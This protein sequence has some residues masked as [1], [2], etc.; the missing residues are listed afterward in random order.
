[1]EKAAICLTFGEQSENHAGMEINGDGLAETGFTVDELRDIKLTLEEKG[2]S[3]E[4]HILNRA[5]ANPE[6]AT[7]AGVL[8]I[9]NAVEKLIGVDAKKMYKE[10]LQFDWDRKYW[11]NRRQKVLNKRARFNVCYGEESVEPDYENKRGTIIGFEKVPILKKLKDNLSVFFGEKASN[12]EVEGNL[13]YDVS[14]CGIGFHGDAERKRVIACSLGVK[15][16]IHWQW[17]QNSKPIGD[18]IKYE[19][20][21]GD[22]Y[23]MSEKA[24]GF[25]WKKRSQKTLRHAAGVKYVN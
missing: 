3:S 16:P 19:I 4:L 12:L 2:I 11:D 5:L 18:R 7:E 20:E 8:F 24:T 14:K 6:D 21:G 17:Y 15:R 23:I 10:Q 9:R 1:M 13:Y 22:M 25:D